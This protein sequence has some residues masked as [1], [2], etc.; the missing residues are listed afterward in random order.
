MRIPNKDD[1]LASLEPWKDYQESDAVWSMTTIRMHPNMD[2]VC[3]EG[4]L[5]TWVQTNDV[6][7]KL[8]QIED[9]KVYRSSL[10]QSGDL[11]LILS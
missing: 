5:K 6:A 8:G 3:L 10:P 7:K 11:N 9:Y 1:R 2:D 4:L